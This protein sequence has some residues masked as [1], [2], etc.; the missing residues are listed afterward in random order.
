[1]RRPPPIAA[2]FTVLTAGLTLIALAAWGGGAHVPA[3]A[4]AVLALWMAGLVLR[5]LFGGRR[6]RGEDSSIR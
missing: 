2:L 4:A 6:P 3:L 1:M 5:L